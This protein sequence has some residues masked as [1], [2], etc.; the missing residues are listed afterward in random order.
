MSYSSLK[1]PA[2]IALLDNSGLKVVTTPTYSSTC[3]NSEFQSVLLVVV[4]DMQT[5]AVT[6]ASSTVVTVSTV[7]ANCTSNCG[8]GSS[9]IPL[10][11]GLVVG[12]GGA[13]ILVAGLTVLVIRRKSKITAAKVKIDEP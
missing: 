5:F 10:I 9:S 1:D 7:T 12:I 8:T 4:C 3:S 2:K 6:N 13:G 11:V